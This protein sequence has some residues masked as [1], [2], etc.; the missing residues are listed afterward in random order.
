MGVSNACSDRRTGPQGIPGGVRDAT[1]VARG[2]GKVV[3]ET[4]HYMGSI[5]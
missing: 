3:T 2:V 4:E 5:Q 1:R